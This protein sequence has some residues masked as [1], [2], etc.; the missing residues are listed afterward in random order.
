VISIYRIIKV[1]R[2]Q[3]KIVQKI[4]VSSK[5]M[6]NIKIKRVI[7]NNRIFNKIITINKKIRSKLISTDIFGTFKCYHIY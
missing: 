6:I 2:K 5:N 7:T 1:K 4:K 3:N